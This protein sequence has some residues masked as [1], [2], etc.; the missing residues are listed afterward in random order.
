M[1]YFDYKLRH[2]QLD[3]R[4][5]KT[6]LIRANKVHQKVIIESAHNFFIDIILFISTEW[7]KT[8]AY[9]AKARCVIIFITILYTLGANS[10]NQN[11]LCLII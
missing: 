7:S 6:G 9:I 11:Y 10:M 4:L 1:H 3:N 8:I 5:G 2:H